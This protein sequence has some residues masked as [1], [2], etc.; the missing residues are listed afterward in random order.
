MGQPPPVVVDFETAG[1][2]A[3]IFRLFTLKGRIARARRR[4]GAPEAGAKAVAVY[5]SLSRSTVSYEIGTAAGRYAESH[6]LPRSVRLPSVVERALSSVAGCSPNVGAVVLGGSSESWRNIP[7][8]VGALVDVGATDGWSIAEVHTTRQLFLV[9][10]QRDDRAEWV[11]QFGSFAELSALHGVLERL[12]G[13]LPDLVSRPVALHHWKGDTWVHAQEGL[14]GLPWF[15][16]RDTWHSLDAWIVLRDR[17]AVALDH[18][19]QAVRRTPDWTGTLSPAAELTAL[20]TWYGGTTGAERVVLERVRTAT[21]E[22]SRLGTIR[23]H[24]QHGDYCFN[25]LLVS[26]E[27]LGL[28]DFEEFGRTSM[29]LHDEFSLAFSTYDIIQ[30]FAGAPSLG[31]L[32]RTGIAPACREAGLE[33]P[34]AG[35]FLLHHLLWRMRQCEARDRRADILAKLRKHLVQSVAGPASYGVAG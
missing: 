9:F 18:F 27:R 17:A 20:G 12:Y 11:V 7:A 31:E 30:A 25:N 32:V 2:G 5:P 33:T 35:G 4:I 21:S 23:S 16:V 10:D 28:I 26:P 19:R 34:M 6:L 29:P 13:L 15:R 8:A 1:P 22:L 14:S 24:W 3:R